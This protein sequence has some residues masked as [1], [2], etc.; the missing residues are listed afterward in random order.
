M[1]MPHH[2]NTNTGVIQFCTS[3]FPVTVFYLCQLTRS[4]SLW[5]EGVWASWPCQHP[6]KGPSAGLLPR[7][8]CLKSQF[9]AGPG[10]LSF[11][12]QHPVESRWQWE[13]RPVKTT[14][15]H[16]FV[17][18]FQRILTT[19]SRSSDRRMSFS[20]WSA[21]FCIWGIRKARLLA[22]FLQGGEEWCQLKSPSPLNNC[23]SFLTV[24]LH[25]FNRESAGVSKD[26]TCTLLMGA[27]FKYLNLTGHHLNI[28]P[29]GD[30]NLWGHASWKNSD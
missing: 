28:C 23:F 12:F 18:A 15:M 27:V 14:Q 29:N 5:P 1:V 21:F 16:R 26:F 9:D 11:H 6:G 8:A 25:I 24:S 3:Y 7:P 22:W 2:G 30:Q 19:A 10:G 13:R 20:T 4:L 17:C